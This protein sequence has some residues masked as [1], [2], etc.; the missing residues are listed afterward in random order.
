[1]KKASECAS[2]HPRA[3]GVDPPGWRALAV[4]FGEPQMR[5]THQ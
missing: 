2:P 3:L 4:T 5:R 1:M